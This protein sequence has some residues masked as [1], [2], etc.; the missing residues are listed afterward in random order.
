MTLRQTRKQRIKVVLHSEE[1]N[2]EDFTDFFFQRVRA[3]ANP[4]RVMTF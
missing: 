1:K 3:G 2:M 4:V